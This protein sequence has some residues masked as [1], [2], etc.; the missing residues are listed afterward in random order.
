MVKI[1]GIFHDPVHF[2]DRLCMYVCILGQALYACMYVCILSL[3]YDSRSSQINPKQ[4]K[5]TQINL[6]QP[7]WTQVNP[8]EIQVNSSES[9]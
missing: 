1:D 4:P 3:Q 2:L 9:K 6:D 5:S 7:K 8:N